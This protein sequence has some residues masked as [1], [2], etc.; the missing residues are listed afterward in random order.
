[1]A[2]KVRQAVV[3]VHGMGEQKP[4]DT[5]RRFIDAALP[6]NRDGADG[7]YSRPDR[8]TDSYESRR[9]LAREYSEDGKE[10]NAQT[11]F[12][13]YHWAHHMQGNRLDDMWPTVRRILLQAPWMVPSG[14]RVI[15]GLFWAVIL[16]AIW[17]FTVGP[18]SGVGPDDLWVDGLLALLGGGLVAWLLVYVITRVLPSWITTSFVDVVRYLDTSPRSYEVRRK[19]RA[20]M[21]DLLVG[22][23]NSCRYQRIVV[24]A[25]SL[26]AYI[27]YDGIS[28]TWARMNKLHKGPASKVRGPGESPGGLSEL[29]IAAAALGKCPSPE[30]LAK[31]KVAQGGLWAGLRAQGNPWLIT[32]FISVGTPMYFADKLFT[33]TRTEFQNAVDRSEMPT[34]PPIAEHE[35]YNNVNGTGLWF[36]W[37]NGHRRVLHDGAPFAVVRWTNMWFP[38]KLGFFGDW[39]AG[40]LAPLFGPGIA[41][42]EL[43]GNKPW[44]L[45]PGYAHA[46]YFKFPEDTGPDSVT[47][48]L[49]D[50]LDLAST[51][52]LTPTLA[53]PEPD[54]ETAIL[55]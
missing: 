14:L 53:A 42:I 35:G 6:K 17:A 47:T 43:S 28:Y 16:V 27:A 11:E 38:A 55:R 49:R 3:I 44:R 24:V 34:A 19:I 1:M 9:F 12:Y 20:G 33:K 26:G 37:K 39:F 13:E 36:S 15:W 2:S 32:D 46:I 23:H 54:A 8:V 5:L 21:V 48:H 41:D 51:D 45:I 31:F 40:P 30:Q 4:L 25:H 18:L 7:F 50:A 10:R 29:E 22:L 52:W